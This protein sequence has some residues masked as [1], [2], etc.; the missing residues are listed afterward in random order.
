MSLE[1]LSAYLGTDEAKKDVVK[2]AQAAGFDVSE[3]DL[4]EISGGESEN[5][6]RVHMF[7]EGGSHTQ[8]F[9]GKE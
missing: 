1:Q 6:S 4:D 2:N 7:N 3:D 8:L 5:L 9:S